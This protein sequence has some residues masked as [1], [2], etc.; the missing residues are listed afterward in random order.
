MRGVARRGDLRL[1]WARCE[2]P[3]ES[4]TS[5]AYRGRT[6][7]Y[8]STRHRGCSAAAA[9]LEPHRRPPHTEACVASLEHAQSASTSPLGCGGVALVSSRRASLFAVWK[10]LQKNRK[11]RGRIRRFSKYVL[12]FSDVPQLPDR[13][14]TQIPFAHLS[15]DL[16][17]SCDTKFGHLCHRSVNWGTAH[18]CKN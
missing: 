14:V 13:S 4:H 15:L 6:R 16:N 18:V 1:R 9:A 2:L 10:V 12:S 17:S 7:R 11:R 8:R 3:P 5:S